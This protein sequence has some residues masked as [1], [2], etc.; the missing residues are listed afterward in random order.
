MDGDG[1]D[2]WD[3]ASAVFVGGGGG[4]LRGRTHRLTGGRRAEEYEMKFKKHIYTYYKYLADFCKRNLSPEKNCS[5]DSCAV[6]KM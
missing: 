3:L 4:G 6:R 2:F 5:D 1:G